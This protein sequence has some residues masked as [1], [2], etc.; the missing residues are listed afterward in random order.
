MTVAVVACTGEKLPSCF[1]WWKKATPL[2][3][4]SAL[5]PFA[6]LAI[7]TPFRAALACF[8]FPLRATLPLNSGFR[9]SAIDVMAGTL[10]ES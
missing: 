10:L 8:G 5:P 9:R 1:S 3:M 2:L 6:R 4:S 7:I